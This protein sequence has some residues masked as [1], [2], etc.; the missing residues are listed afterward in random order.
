MKKAL[1]L[2]VMAGIFTSSYGQFI[3]KGSVIANGSFSFYSTKFK[4]SEDKYSGF[5]IMPWAGY[6]VA[7]NFAVGLM[8]SYENDVVKNDNLNS[9]TTDNTFQVGPVI[10]YYLNNGFFAQGTVGFGKVKSKSE[11]DGSTS[12][13]SEYDTFEYR[14]GIGYAIRITESVFFDPVIGF[15]S[16]KEKYDSGDDT[17]TGFFGMG[18]FTIKLK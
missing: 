15:K 13:D 5:D 2:V 17:E 14:I 7:D 10:R 11:Y 16:N 9:K 4:D 6:F 12:Y 1:L 18:S 3:D 8:F